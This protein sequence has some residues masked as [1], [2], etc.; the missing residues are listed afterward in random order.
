MKERHPDEPTLAD[1]KARARKMHD[2]LYEPGAPGFSSIGKMYT[3][4]PILTDEP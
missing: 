4:C 2:E 1:V 3:L